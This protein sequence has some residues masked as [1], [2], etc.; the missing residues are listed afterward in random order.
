VAELKGDFKVKFLSFVG[1][2]HLKSAPQLTTA[3]LD[4]ETGDTDFSTDR[5]FNWK[6]TSQ[7]FIMG[8]KLSVS[9]SHILGD[10][11]YPLSQKIAQVSPQAIVYC[12]AADTGDFPYPNESAGI[13]LIRFE[14]FPL[15]ELC[16]DCQWYPHAKA[17]GLCF[18]AVIV[19]PV[20]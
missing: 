16:L 7:F 10:R 6:N 13:P 5:L 4:T 20:G 15:L 2:M 1:W 14:S 11:L 12:D 17:W 9:E 18:L 19:L 8:E 3:V